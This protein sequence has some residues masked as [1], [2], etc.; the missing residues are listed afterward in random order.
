M[1]F[2]KDHLITLLDDLYRFHV[3]WSNIY[4]RCYLYEVIDLYV[5]I[6]LCTKSFDFN[7]VRM[8]FCKDHLITL[9][10]DLYRFQVH[11]SIIY[12]RCYLYEVID[13]YVCICLCT[14][15]FDF[16]FVRMDFCKD[17]L[18]TLLDDLYRFQVHWSIIYPRCYLYEVID[19]YVCICLCTKSFDFNFV[20][21][22]FCKDHLITLLD[23]LY[24][25]Q[26]HW[27]IIYPRCYLYE[28][29]D[30]YVCICLCT[31]SFDFNFVRMDFCKD[32][33][34]TLLDDLYR[35][36]VHWSNIYPRCYLYEVIDL[37]VYICLCTKSF[38][39]N[40]V[41]MDFCKDQLIA[42]LDD[43][44]RFQVHWSNIYPRCYLYEVIDLYVYICLCTKS[45]DFNYVRMDFCKDHVITLL[46][47]LY[48]F[49]VHWSNIYPRCYLYEVIDLYL[50]ICV[51]TKSF[52]FNFL[53]LDAL[54]NYLIALLDDLYRFQVHWSNIY[55]R[56]YLY[57]VID[58]Y[59]YIC[60]CTKSF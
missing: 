39:F 8:D 45:F 23:D 13:L 54:Q 16:N 1:D 47:D 52:D 49:Q 10:D 4:P 17:H 11:W 6:C 56:C 57:E 48:Q 31:K 41:H 35:F 5:Y 46:D 19:L 53:L 14:K 3:R 21:M 26:V 58:L 32:H 42:L 27:S 55:P 59:V 34:I 28:V 51:C 36:Q 37:Y 12:P 40:F 60:L 50:Y 33:L 22:D 18:I 2:C 38:D 43:L 29:I 24:R 15:S 20:R 30:L 44:Y 25:F 7:F 9:L